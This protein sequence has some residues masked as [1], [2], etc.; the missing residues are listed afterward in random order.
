MRHAN[1]LYSL[2]RPAEARALLERITAGTWHDRF[3]GFEYQ[4]K[5]LLE[6][7]E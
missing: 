4:A 2:G 3:A 5:R 7:V 1:A 6:Q